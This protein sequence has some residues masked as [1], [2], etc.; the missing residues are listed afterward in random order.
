MKCVPK[1]IG[2]ERSDF[3]A[4]AYLS[5]GEDPRTTFFKN[6]AAQ[7]GARLQ[8]LREWMR[9]TD[10]LQFCQAHPEAATWFG[11]DGVPT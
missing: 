1:F 10:W 5:E 9:E 4:E 11:E 2:Y 7:R 6:M 8:L 3:D